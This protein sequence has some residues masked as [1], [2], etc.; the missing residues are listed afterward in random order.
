V[1]V[2]ASALN[3]LR[4]RMGFPSASDVEIVVLVSVLH[5]SVN[6]V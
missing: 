5:L 1:D 4:P 3:E 6:L 2:Q